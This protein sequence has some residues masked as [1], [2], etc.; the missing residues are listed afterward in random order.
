MY[1]EA[2]LILESDKDSPGTYSL[3]INGEEISDIVTGL[4]LTLEACELPKLSLRLNTEKISIR[5]RC[6]VEVPEV[7]SGILKK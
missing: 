2:E 7:Y 6:L 5:S 1:K 4:S 3:K